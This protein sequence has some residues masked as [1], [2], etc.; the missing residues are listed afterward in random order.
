MEAV[1]EQ[2]RRDIQIE[3]RSRTRWSGAGAIVAFTVSY[4]GRDPK[5]VA[6]VVNTLASSYLEENTRSASGRPPGTAGF[7]RKQLEEVKGRL[8]EQEARVSDFKRRYIG[9]P[10][11]TWTRTSRRSS[12]SPRSSG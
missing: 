9:E 7:L 6:E 1:I 5:T 4:T 11:R 10:R 8:D 2:M 3:L 12:G